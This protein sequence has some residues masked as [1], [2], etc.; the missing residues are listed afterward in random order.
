M[1]LGNGVLLLQR[2]EPPH[3]RPDAPN[4]ILGDQAVG[5]PLGPAVSGASPSAGRGEMF[6]KTYQTRSFFLK[7]KSKFMVIVKP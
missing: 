2:Q 6:L 4:K 5:A 3:S 1:L 7:L